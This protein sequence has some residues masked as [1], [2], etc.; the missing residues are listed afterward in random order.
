MKSYFYLIVAFALLVAG[1][2]TSNKNNS[3]Q[4]VYGETKL[5]LT[6]YN[7]DFELYAEIDPFVVG[8]TASLIAHFTHLSD[9]KALKEGSVTARLA[10][11][12]VEIQHNLEKPTA[13]G[14]YIFHLKPENE[15]V[16]SLTFDVVTDQGNSQLIISEVEVF[17]DEKKAILSTNEKINF[18]S[19]A[20]SFSKEQSW[21]MDFATD[22]PKVEAFGQVI[23]T[24]AQV[25]SAPNDEAVVSAN[26]NGVVLFSPDH[27]L[28]GMEVSKEQL[29]YSI[30]SSGLA[31]S[32][33]SIQFLEAQNNYVK[34]K[35]DYERMSELVKD[36]IVSERDLLNA[37]NQ[38]NNAKAV[39][40]NYSK[41]FTAS[42]QKI[43]SPMDGY[44]QQVL[45]QNGQYVEAGQA[46]VIVS[47][48]KT[49]MLRAEVQQKY[50]SILSAL[51][52]AT[53]RS[54]H[55]T[56]TYTLEELNGK[57]L[58]F[59]RSAGHDNYLL[60][61]SLQIE[62]NG[63]FVPGALVE[64][65]LKTMTNAQ[66]LTIPNSALI[67]EQ[68]NYFVF[69]QIHPELFEKREVKVGATDG[70]RTEII[71]GVEPQNRIVT[72][73]AIMVKLAEAS[74]DLD[75]HSGHMH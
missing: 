45:V 19:T 5:P 63:L 55:G 26:S 27:M 39:Y 16:G 50:A 57:I 1:C 10:V 42:G 38:Y 69:V 53:I 56:Q 37:K 36:K 65:Y 6:N 40:D 28:E 73:G 23:K 7:N 15:G 66:A 12:G 61:I 30:S 32:N 8:K 48:N 21:K 9:F 34:S 64:V 71:K 58:S 33:A 68:G 59:G 67:E 31:N 46:I 47:Q 62:N 44:I 18:P 51:N 49:L 14:I 60:P 3:H 17:T 25:L 35:S 29:L 43:V 75:A 4:E 54:M 2:N 11:N 22:H 52:S 41:N 70:L 74:G 72:I 13:K 20:T 24:T